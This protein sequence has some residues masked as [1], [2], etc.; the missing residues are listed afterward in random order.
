M[1]LLTEELDGLFK[2]QNEKPAVKAGELGR[3]EAMFDETSASVLLVGL[4]DHFGDQTCRGSDWVKTEPSQY[5]KDER[6]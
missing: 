6:H 3:C 5:H 4:D 2:T 1:N